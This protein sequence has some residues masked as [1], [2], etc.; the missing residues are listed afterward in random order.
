MT[1]VSPSPIVEA[2]DVRVWLRASRALVVRDVSLSISAG[3]ILGL[4]GESGS[5]KTSLALAMLGMAKPQLEITGGEIWIDG[6]SMLDASPLELQ[7]LRGSH[8][9][10]VP[11]DPVAALD[12]GSRIG[13]QLSEVL[14]VHGAPGGSSV[15]TRIGE[16]LV[17]VGL[18]TDRAFLRRYPHQLSG[19]QLQ[20]VTIAM[21]FACLPRAVV[22][23][24]PTTGLD[25]TT[26][27]HVLD[28][29]KRMCRSHGVATLYVSHD[30]AVVGQLADRVAVMYAGEVIE[31]GPTAE[32]LLSPAH[33]YTQR[34]LAAAPS[35]ENIRG[36]VG[37]PGTAPTPLGM[38]GGC[39][40]APRCD[41]TMDIC[42]SVNPD[43]RTVHDAHRARC[44]LI[45]SSLPT[46]RALAATPRKRDESRAPRVD[47]LV[48]DQVTAGF[49]PSRGLG[50]RESGRE[51]RRV[52]GARRR[53]RQREDNPCPVHRRSP[54]HLHRKRRGQ[55]DAAGSRG[56]TQRTVPQR[57]AVQYVFQNPYSSL[58]PRK[59]VRESLRL[60]IAVF[61]GRKT[62]RSSD[63]R[64]VEALERV[65]LA[66]RLPPPVPDTAERWRTPTCR[67]RSC[68]DRPTSV[69]DL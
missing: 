2:R 44:H 65:S 33:P 32:A 52:R 26:Q 56:S 57:R 24:E 43:E 28:T 45:G 54:R 3:E 51:G 40:F 21:A 36:L 10:Y 29:L 13:A 15:A 30:L 4:V 62:A 55:R 8:V 60:P 67:H 14:E 47:Q 42:R 68:A 41:H 64:L 39:A 6:V 38:P 37:I 5:G 18:P 17:E 66:R 7:Q 59:T 49:G 20:R 19:G 31:A 61:E 50:R 11:Q 27:A 34:L 22:L 63:D 23:D 58:N 25:V 16:V 53:V 35:L 9:S 46:S 12:P 69:P 1:R 48:V